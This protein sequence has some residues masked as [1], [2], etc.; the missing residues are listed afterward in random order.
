MKSLKTIVLALCMVLVN[1]AWAQQNDKTPEARATEHS[2]KLTK[3]LNLTAD[4]QKTVYAACLQRAQQNEADR[5]KFEGNRDGM[6]AA[7][8]Q[9]NQTFDAS[10]DKILTADQKTQYEKMKQDEKAKRQQ[11]GGGHQGGE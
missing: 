1:F 11:G 6:R 3:Q 7:R 9:N 8:Q 4:Q 5:T 2:Q 10:L